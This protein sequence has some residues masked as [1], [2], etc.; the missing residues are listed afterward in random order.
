MLI[1]KL[2]YVTDEIFPVQKILSIQIR[3]NNWDLVFNNRMGSGLRKLALYGEADES[4]VV[5]H[6]LIPS[7]QYNFKVIPKII[8]VLSRLPNLSS[9]KVVV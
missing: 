5:A 6:L 8:M 1:T 2:Q 9:Q 4:Y 7:L 3:K